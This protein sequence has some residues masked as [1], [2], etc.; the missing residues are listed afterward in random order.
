MYIYIYMRG[1]NIPECE[2]CLTLLVSSLASFSSSSYR[3][4]PTWTTKDPE[5]ADGD[6]QLNV[7]RQRTA[8]SKVH[9]VL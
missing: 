8:A 7:E 1:M 5:Q 4:F 9:Y 3:P 2:E 6:T